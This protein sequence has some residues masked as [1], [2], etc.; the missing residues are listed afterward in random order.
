LEQT[1]KGLSV[2]YFSNINLSISAPRV[3][4]L[5]ARAGG[6]LTAK[7]GTSMATPHV[8]GVAALSGEKLIRMVGKIEMMAPAA[9][10]VASGTI[11]PLVRPFDDLDV[12]TGIVQAPRG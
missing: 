9:K 2:A 11:D 8:A 3:K 4:I 12:G 5:S 7:S 10:L 1:Q 6:G